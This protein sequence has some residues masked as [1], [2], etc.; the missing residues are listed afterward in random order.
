MTALSALYERLS[1]PHDA[2]LAN[3]AESTPER[4]HLQA[5]ESIDHGTTSE[6]FPDPAALDS[7]EVAGL[8]RWLDSF[9]TFDPSDLSWLNIVPGDLLA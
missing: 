3:G 7:Q 5:V 1:L 8:F 4:A 6:A 2:H 9:D